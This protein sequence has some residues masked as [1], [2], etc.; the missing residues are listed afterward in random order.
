MLYRIYRAA[1]ARVFVLSENMRRLI[2]R[3]LCAWIALIS[4]V[5]MAAGDLADMLDSV[6]SGA[7]SGTKS[8]LVIAQFAGVCGVIGSIFAL[9]AMKNN[10][11]IR[12]WMV[13]LTFFGS[14]V[15]IAV[16]E[17]IKRGQTQMNMTPVSVG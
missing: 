14:L 3:A 2:L 12:P 13:G 9:K 4:P 1:F 6:S 11:Q 17:I 10:P 7:E 15:L 8:V 16:P 5:A